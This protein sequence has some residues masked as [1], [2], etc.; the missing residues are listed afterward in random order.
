MD[1]GGGTTDV[2]VFKQGR[3]SYSGV[4][5]IGGYQFTNDIAITFNTSYEAAEAA[6]LEYGTTELAFSAGSEEISLPAVGSDVELKVKRLEISQLT[7]ERA[8]ELARLI[9]LKLE[10]AQIG[11]GSDLRLVL[12]GGASN[13]PGLPGLIQRSLSISARHG[14][15]SARGQLPPE[16][17]NPAYATGVGILLWAVNEYVAELSNGHVDG[18][19]NIEVRPKGIF[20][21]IFGLLGQS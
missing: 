21:G 7:R 1:V 16:F 20:S 9:G 15:P 2:V 6:K 5:P 8:L 17:R 18:D 13:L 14:I 12:T 3:I 19:Q 10:D 11:D 4:I